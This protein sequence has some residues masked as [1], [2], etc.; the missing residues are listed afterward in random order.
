MSG[1][2]CFF[3]P[4]ESNASS[5]YTKSTKQK[6]IFKDVV[7]QVQNQ[8]NFIK[9]NGVNYNEN[10]G[11]HNNCLAFAKSYDLLLDVTKG[12]YYTKPVEDPNWVSNEAW[13]A[14]LYSVDYSGNNV[15]A[16]VDTSYNAGNSNH[17][18]FPMTQPAYLADL[19]WN[20]LY[21]GVRV[22]P[23]YNIFYNECDDQNYWREK[24]VDMSFNTTNYSIQSKQQS[25][26]LYG[27]VYPGNVTFSC[28]S[29]RYQSALVSI[30]QIYISSDYGNTWT[31][32]DSNRSWNDIAMSADGRRQTAVVNNGQIYVSIDF[33][34]TWSAKDS[35][36][37]W[38]SIAMTADGSRQTAVVN[39]GQ[40]YIS[41]DFG[42]TWTPKDSINF[43]TSI[44]ITADGSRQTAV[45]VGGN[46]YIS[47]NFGNTWIPKDSVRTWVSIAMSADGSRQTAVVSGGNIYI[48]IDYGFIWTPKD[49]VR[50]WTSIAMTADGSRQTAVVSNGQIYISSDYGNTW[51]AK[52]SNRQWKSIAMS[53]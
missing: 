13:S 37:N 7:N 48:S 38:T 11:L 34:D 5:D 18:I 26:Q 25:E 36:R 1:D 12:K 31:A 45:V 3:N 27:I 21:P 52:D 39:N 22:D 51:V 42:N 28:G 44:A 41:T 9:S 29:G 10:F 8:T 33:G 19:S 17:I 6:T 40:I 23:S 2:K 14:G 20:G 30:G 15:K 32:K 53:S 50:N 46:I 49:S 35:V 16:V 43:W 4:N 24:L 47:S